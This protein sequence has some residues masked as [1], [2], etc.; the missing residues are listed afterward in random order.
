[1]SPVPP[2]HERNT[3]VS[4]SPIDNLSIEEKAGLGSGGSFWRTRE[5]GTVT[6]FMLTDGPH[7][8]R[9]QGGSADHLGLAESIPATCF[10]PAVAM[11]QSWNPDLVTRVAKLSE[12]NAKPNRSAF[13]SAPASTSSATRAAAATSSTTPKTRTSAARSAPHG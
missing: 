3:P 6:S 1:M 2:T 4:T 11:A 5:A 13:C 8:L 10:P 9:K 7:G 12:R